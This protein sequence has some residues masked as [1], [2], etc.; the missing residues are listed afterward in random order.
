MNK[1]KRHHYVPESYQKQFWDD[2][3]E[4]IFFLDKTTGKKGGTNPINLCVKTNLYTMES[5]LDGLSLTEIENPLL[6]ELDGRYIS[7]IEDIWPRKK[8]AIDRVTL[9]VFI[10]FL[11]C[12]TPS[13]IEG[14][15]EFC[16][17]QK[18]K[19][20]YDHICKSVSLVE[21]AK[22]YGINTSSLDT[23]TSEISNFGPTLNKDGSLT[24]F[25]ASAIYNSFWIA[26]QSWRVLLSVDGEF[27]TSDKPFTTVDEEH[28]G[29][30]ANHVERFFIVPLSS[31]VCLEIGYGKKEL[32]VELATDLEIQEIN[33]AVA[34]CADRWLLG[35]SSELLKS[36]YEKLVELDV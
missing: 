18:Q 4:R 33:M 11:R 13:F 5:A 31:H 12:R 28:E 35:R 20:L 25:L 27:I 7:A 34:Y 29:N 1:P 26:S 22:S 17:V 14:F 6:S 36:M 8:E 3:L 10:A 16:S 19:E 24:G 30:G 32:Q 15:S 2:S 9:S 23:F 21:Q